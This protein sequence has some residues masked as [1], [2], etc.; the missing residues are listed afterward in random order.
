[1]SDTQTENTNETDMD[2][3]V[4]EDRSKQDKPKHRRRGLGSLLFLLILVGG[5]VAA[6]HYQSMWLP[7][8]KEVW[9]PQARELLADLWP[10]EEEIDVMAA[11]AVDRAYLGKTPSG[12]TYVLKAI[13]DTQAVAASTQETAQQP[14]TEIAATHKA[15]DEAVD[16]TSTDSV[17]EADVTAVSPAEMPAEQ[18]AETVLAKAEDKPAEVV[19]HDAVAA[20]PLEKPPETVSARFEDSPAEVAEVKTGHMST[21]ST[22]QAP[23]ATDTVA[24][25]RADEM[26]HAGM[27]AEQ[28]DT[29]AD[30]AAANIDISQARQA[31]WA[32]NLALAE[33]AYKKVLEGDTDN[34]DAWGELG[35]VYYMQAKWAQAA[36]AYA[37]AAIRLLKKG[38]YRQAMYM[39]Y[40]VQGLDPKQAARVDA[41]LK[42]MQAPAQG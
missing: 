26:A 27:M 10:A 8:A 15:A 39:R 12:N 37:E 34:A 25:A 23:Q 41:Q 36:E 24:V 6:W 22:T 1:M 19:E 29:L 3:V 13:P 17:V 21:A 14:A 2:E 31:Y 32:R 4:T 30:N 40:V 11:P 16:N 5:G 18:P 9:L 20:S 28:K 35:N 7:Q 33:T 38:D 42:R